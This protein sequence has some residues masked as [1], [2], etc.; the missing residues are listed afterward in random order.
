MFK[1]KNFLKNKKREKLLTSKLFFPLYFFQFF[2][3]IT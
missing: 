2:A 3:Q 1:E